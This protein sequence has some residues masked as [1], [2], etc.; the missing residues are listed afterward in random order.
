MGNFEFV[1]KVVYVLMLGLVGGAMFIESLNTIR[2]SKAQPSGP[3]AVP[4]EPKLGKALQLPEDAFTR[5][6]LHTSAIFLFPSVPLS[7]L[8]CAFGRRRRLH[9]GRP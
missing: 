6:G 5:S 4:A 1:M 8:C 2:R 3:P 7:V 9:H